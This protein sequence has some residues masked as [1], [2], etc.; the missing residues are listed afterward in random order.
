MSDYRITTQKALRAAFWRDYPRLPRVPGRTQNDYSAG[1]R[2]LWCQYI[3]DK[4]KDGEISEALAQR[5]TL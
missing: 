1:I 2:I 4:E 5:A 3:D